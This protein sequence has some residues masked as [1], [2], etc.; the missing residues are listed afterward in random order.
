MTAAEHLLVL[1]EYAPEI[2]VNT[3]I[4]DPSTVQD[5]KVFEDAASAVGAKVLWASVSESDQPG[6]HDPLKLAA[7]YKQVFKH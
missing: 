5:K 1:R 6:V 7:A 3:V 2:R 4:S